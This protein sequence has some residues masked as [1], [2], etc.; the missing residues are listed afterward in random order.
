M[1]THIPSARERMQKE[2]HKRRVW[3]FLEKQM[4]KQTGADE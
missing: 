2:A 4:R 1:H 3:A